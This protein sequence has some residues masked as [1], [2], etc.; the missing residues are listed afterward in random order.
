LHPGP[1]QNLPYDVF[2]SH[3]RAGDESGE[4]GDECEK[5]QW[6]TGKNDDASVNIDEKTHS[7]K[8]VE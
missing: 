2:I 3:Y 7:L 1:G 5:V 4:H 8:Y 6:V